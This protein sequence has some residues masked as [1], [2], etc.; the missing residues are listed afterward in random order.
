[1][2][3]STKDMTNGS[4]TRLLLSFALPLICGNLFQQF[5]SMVDSIIVGK[6]LG[7]DALAAVGCTGS[8]N[9]LII[10]FCTGSCAGMTIPVAQCF[11]ARD[12]DGLRRR[13]A[14]GIWLSAFIAIVMALLTALNCQRILLRMRTPVNILAD[15]NAYFTVILFGIPATILYNFSSSI[16]RAL[17]DSRRPLY[18]LIFSSLLNVA[19]D[20][21]FIVSFGWGVVGAAVATVISQLTA[22]L[23]CVVYIVRSLP[24]LHMEQGDW[25][26]KAPLIKEL[27]SA[28]LP[29]G[30]QFSITAIGTVVLSSAVNSL[31]STAVASMTAA[32]KITGLFNC[33]HDAMGSAMATYCGQNLGARKLSRVNRGLKSALAIMCCYAVFV[34][35]VM[36][37]FGNQLSMLFVDSAETDILANVRFY[38]IVNTATSPLLAVVNI[39]RNSIQ[40][41]GYS[42]FAL[43]AGVFEMFARALV[44]FLLV[45]FFGFRGACF[46]NTSAWLAADLFLVPGYLRVMR[47][48]R[49]RIPAE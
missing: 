26:P 2:A 37:L 33:A 4:P 10:G 35:G 18:F 15:A 1:M 12:M 29:M 22:G 44:A 31:G 28:G 40:G 38:L 17:G 21:L 32:G 25:T 13:V 39:M 46:A 23:L 8:L 49:A 19:L 36:L 14:N 11:G 48:L 7:A 27:T 47:G 6:F 3:G 43:F 45:P 5:Y 30:L 16:M 34:L 42:N 41:L 20:L 9:F 24:I